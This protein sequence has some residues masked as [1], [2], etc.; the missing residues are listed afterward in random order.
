MQNKSATQESLNFNGPIK[1][2]RFKFK[3]EML[4]ILKYIK[5]EF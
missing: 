2:Q 1:P 5:K 4:K 3:F